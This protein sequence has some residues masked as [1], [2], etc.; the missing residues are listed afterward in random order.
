M[1]SD[2][3][4]QKTIGPARGPQPASERGHSGATRAPATKNGQWLEGVGILAV[5]TTTVYFI[6]LSWR[7]WCHPI[8]DSGR[9]LYT[10][11]RLSEGAVLYRDVDDV[12]G[13]LSQY[14]NA[15]LFKLFGPGMMVLAV[16]NLVIF[17]G[18]LGLAYL[19]FRRAWGAVGALGASVVFLTVFAFCPLLDINIFNYA[20]PYSHEATHGMLVMVGLIVAVGR[21]VE[22]PRVRWCGVAG[23]LVG[24]ALVLKPEF[25]FAAALLVVTA[26]TLRRRQWPQRGGMSV[27]VFAVA[28][29]VP[30]VVFT[31]YFMRH[32]PPLEALS[33]AGRAW[34]SLLLMPDI[35]ATPY[36]ISSAGWDH[37]VENFIQHIR[38]TALVMG[39]LGGIGGWV[40]LGLRMRGFRR[41]IMLMV[42]VAAALGAGILADWSAIGKSLLGS[43]LIYLCFAW[44]RWR[45]SARWATGEQV[46]TQ[47]WRLLLA[48]VA[49]AMMAR[50]ILNGRIVQFGFFQAV[51][52]AMVVTAV[53]CAEAAEWM[54][55]VKERRLSV[56]LAVAGL[57]L[58]GLVWAGMRAREYYGWQTLAVA[59][60]RDRFYHFEPEIEASGQLM[61]DVLGVLRELP[62]ET[63]LLALPE[64][65]MVNYLARLRSPLPQ[66]QYYSFTTEAGREKGIVDAL[67][68]RPP[69][70]VVVISR[71]GLG[72][73]GI[74]RYGERDGA[75]RQIIEW[76]NQNYRIT[77]RFGGDPL[78][79]DQRGAYI[80]SRIRD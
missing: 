65:S 3:V 4:S 67:R 17:A 40:A 52:A 45:R 19:L 15:A 43:V 35:L 60:A 13:P 30:T 37:P 80:L 1:T 53:I 39:V 5:I 26:V 66:F 50:M 7:K 32:F 11:W 16:A 24:L 69:D 41:A 74:V 72:D 49:S 70:R 59:D 77:H 33:A 55:N 34:W 71:F 51:L 6:V 38:K 61:N 2:R 28:A 54:P 62:R 73:F 79:T 48:V 36:Q 12:Y 76:V 20:L 44:F 10:P 27:L 29:S 25:I 21:W 46:A 78:A 22:V 23:G 64:G 75:G 63:T 56:V 47:Q 18:I 9:E 31:C 58:P 68:L 42:A 8:V 57:L 14:F